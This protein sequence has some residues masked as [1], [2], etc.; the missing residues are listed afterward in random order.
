MSP[1]WGWFLN[2]AEVEGDWRDVPWAGSAALP[3]Q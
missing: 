1:Q 2:T 3:G